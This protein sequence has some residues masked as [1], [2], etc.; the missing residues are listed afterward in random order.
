MKTP[1]EFCGKP[2]LY[3]VWGR[4]ACPRCCERW[5]E[6]VAERFPAGADSEAVQ[7]LTEELVKQAKTK[8]GVA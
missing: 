8:R 1:C 4:R 7:A 6:V 2:S 5:V 3:A